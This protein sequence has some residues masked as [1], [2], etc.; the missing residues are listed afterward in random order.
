MLYSRLLTAFAAAALFGATQAHA[1]SLTFSFTGGSSSLDGANGNSRTFNSNPAGYT[2]TARAYNTANSD[3]TGAFENAYLGSFSSGL[4]V[5]SNDDGNGFNDAHTVDNNG[6]DNLVGFYFNTLVDLSQI[7]LEGY[8][9]TDIVVYL[10]TV[11]PNFALTGFSYAS[12]PAGFSFLGLF[13]NSETYNINSALAGNY[14]II[15]AA[16]NSNAN[17][18][19]KIKSLTVDTAAVPEPATMLLLGSG[20]AGAV[21]ARRRAAK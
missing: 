7:R 14:L 12:L 18:E 21:R 15:G 1:V 11:A 10:G 6:D 13:Q 3:G 17:D 19:F 5:T 20:L 16:P 4:G 8:G 2:V 9:D